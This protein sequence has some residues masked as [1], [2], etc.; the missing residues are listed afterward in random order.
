MSSTVVDD[1]GNDVTIGGVTFH[2]YQGPPEG[3]M[4]SYMI[5][6]NTTYLDVSFDFVETKSVALYYYDLHT[7]IPNQSVR[8]NIVCLADDKSESAHLDGI[9]EGEEY[10]AWGQDDNYITDIIRSRIMD[11]KNRK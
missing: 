7:L 8:Y 6:P 3:A 5:N 11:L 2:N 10:A 1:S 9:I 4:F